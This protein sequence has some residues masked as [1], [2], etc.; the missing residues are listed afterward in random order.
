M[1][2][3]E[4][5]VVVPVREEHPHERARAGGDVGRQQRRDGLPVG[6]V[7]G[8]AVEG[9]PARPDQR[10]ADQRQWQIVVATACGT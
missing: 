9:V 7:R 4:A 1:F 8:T 6:G 3:A 10:R 2:N 5:P